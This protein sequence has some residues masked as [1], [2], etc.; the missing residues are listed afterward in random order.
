[1]IDLD[2]AKWWADLAHKCVT[3]IGVTWLTIDRLWER[4]WKAEEFIER[5][6][7]D[8][9]HGMGLIQEGE[10]ALTFIPKFEKIIADAKAVKQTPESQQLINDIEA[11]VEEIKNA[12]APAPVVPTPEPPK[13]A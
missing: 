7:G 1:M 11:L 4:F 5:R 12:V 13:A 2:N 10:L 6:I 8:R 9:R 3:S